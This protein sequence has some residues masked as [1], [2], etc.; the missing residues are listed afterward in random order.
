MMGLYSDIIR[1]KTL[2]TI[3]AVGAGGDLDRGY[4]TAY[5]CTQIKVKLQYNLNYGKH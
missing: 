5:V 3:E 4:T 1:P 2:A